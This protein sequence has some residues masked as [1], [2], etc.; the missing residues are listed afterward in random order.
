MKATFAFN[1]SKPDELTA[2][3]DDELEVIKER[4]EWYVCRSMRG[5]GLVPSNHTEP[6]E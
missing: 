3:K 5:E 2:Q 1:A 4:G 6:A